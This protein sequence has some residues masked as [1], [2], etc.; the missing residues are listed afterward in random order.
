MVV[1]RRMLEMGLLTL[2]SFEFHT[3]RTWAPVF[4]DDGSLGDTDVETVRRHFPDA[5]IIRRDEADRE[6]GRVLENHPACWESR[7]KHNWFLKNFDTWHFAPHAR[8][9]VIDSDIVFFRRPD[10]LL[11]WVDSGE[12]TLWVMEDTNEKYALPREELESRLGFPLWRRVNSGL[13]LMPR[14]AFDLDLAEKYLEECGPIARHFQF[15][16][17]TFFAVTGSRWGRGG[18]LPPEYEISWGNFRRRDGVCRHYVGPFKDDLL[19]IEGGTTFWLQAR[20]AG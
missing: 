5:R 10:H 15:L 18:T 4:H 12:D 3:G 8:Y 14:A 17:Q 13:D 6:L 7:T 11:R 20:R 1:G 16:E 9:I 19:W 2:R